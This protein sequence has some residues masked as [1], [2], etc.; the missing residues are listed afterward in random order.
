[1]SRQIY[2]LQ[3]GEKKE[4]SRDSMWCSV[5]LSNIQ[6]FASIK[7]FKLPEWTTQWLTFS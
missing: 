7:G 6:Q 1:M 4:V 2:S 3:K 5:S